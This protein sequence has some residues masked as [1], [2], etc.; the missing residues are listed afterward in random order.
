MQ[1]IKIPGSRTGLCALLG[2]PVGHS[3]SPAL[4]NCAFAVTGLD[5][6]YLAFAVDDPAAAVA[7]VR[8]LG[9]R[10]CSVTIPH[11]QAVLPLVDHL[12]AEARETGAVNT[13]V[14]DGGV[15]TGCNTDVTGIRAVL[16][17][18]GFSADTAAVILGAGG[19]ARAALVAV[20]QSGCRNVTIVNRSVERAVSLVSEFQS[21][22][23]AARIRVCEDS[24]Q[25]AGFV[26]Q[27]GLLINATSVGMVP[28][29][30]S[31]PIESGLLHPGLTVFDLVYTPQYTAL[32]RAAVDAGAA[33]LTGDR[34]FL[35][36]A[37]DQFRLWT[38]VSPPLDAMAKQ[39]EHLLGYRQD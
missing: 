3:L 34:M 21:R 8:A 5:F 31:M 24:S 1:Q 12:T 4:H 27:A 16:R 37:A 18:S 25:T 19:V 33:V 11:K 30:M 15:L 7:A 23:P 22:F 9:I 38:G 2:N 14:N 6:V 10:G 32:I 26:R 29:V 17:D 39:L 36:Q 13:L 20:L 35:Y 28:D